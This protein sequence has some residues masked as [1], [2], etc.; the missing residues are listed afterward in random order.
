[1]FLVSR[2]RQQQSLDMMVK[3]NAAKNR[4]NALI[5]TYMFKGHLRLH[6]LPTNNK[7]VFTCSVSKF[8][9]NT[10]CEFMTEI[11]NTIEMETTLS[12]PMPDDN[13]F[14]ADPTTKVMKISSLM[15]RL[16]KL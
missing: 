1:M 5:T 16:P 11:I 12:I 3:R 9:G 4:R 10:L 6:L 8:E 15:P 7:G 14:R 13:L 2:K